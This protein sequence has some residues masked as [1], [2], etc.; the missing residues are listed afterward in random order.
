M[1][2]R[3]CCRP[4]QQEQG[5]HTAGAAAA[6]PTAAVA[7]AVAAAATAAAAAVA[8]T[9]AVAPL[10][11]TAERLWGLLGASLSEDPS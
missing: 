5:A 6:A 10:R 2:K 9:R 11:E 8:A 3:R 7:I 4:A 1:E